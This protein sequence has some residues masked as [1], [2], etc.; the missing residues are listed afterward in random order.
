LAVL[1][2]AGPTITTTFVPAAAAGA[3]FAAPLRA[4][5]AVAS[6]MAVR[7]IDHLDD[8]RWA[9]VFG[10]SKTLASCP[11]EHRVVSTR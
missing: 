3:G 7:R 4:T 5:D 10:T 11:P 6:A 9:P 8:A 2:P 1:E